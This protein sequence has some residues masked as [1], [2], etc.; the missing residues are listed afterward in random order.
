[1][2]PLRFSKQSPS[3]QQIDP[4]LTLPHIGGMRQESLPNKHLFRICSIFTR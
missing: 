3:Y 2:T 4:L 1:M